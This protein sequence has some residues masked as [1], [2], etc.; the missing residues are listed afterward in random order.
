MTVLLTINKLPSYSTPFTVKPVSVYLRAQN[1]KHKVIIQAS[2]YK[3]RKKAVTFGSVI[4]HQVLC[5]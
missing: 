2:T 4:D 5:R 1:K 3:I